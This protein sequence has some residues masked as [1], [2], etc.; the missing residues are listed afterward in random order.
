MPAAAALFGVCIGLVVIVL[1][2]ERDVYRRQKA[3]YKDLYD[4]NQRAKDH[5]GQGQ[6]EG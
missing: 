3:K 1:C 4:A 6:E 2:G 5:D